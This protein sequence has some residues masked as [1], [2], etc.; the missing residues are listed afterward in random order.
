[1]RCKDWMRRHMNMGGNQVAVLALLQLAEIFAVKQ[2]SWLGPDIFLEGYP[3]A[4]RDAVGV[5]WTGGKLYVFGGY[6]YN[7]DCL[8]FILNLSIPF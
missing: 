7:G 3:P 1:M 5:A 8:Y 4:P 6:G 2:R